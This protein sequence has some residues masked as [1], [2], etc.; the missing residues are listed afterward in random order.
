MDADHGYP[1]EAT[2]DGLLWHKPTRDGGAAIR[3]TNFSA[4]I[5]TDTVLDDGAEQTH[6]FTIQASLDG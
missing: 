1:Y 2:K 5:V 3:L 4:T 6:M